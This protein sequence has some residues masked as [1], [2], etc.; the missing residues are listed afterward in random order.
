MLHAIYVTLIIVLNP[1]RVLALGITLRR[2]SCA[3]RALLGCGA[4]LLTRGALDVR[5][6][7]PMQ[8]KP[9]AIP[10]VSALMSAVS[11]CRRP[12]GGRNR[13]HQVPVDLVLLAS[14]LL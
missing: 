1:T 2:P 11:E 7:R 4:A 5:K 10:R 6:R 14:P 9:H 12:A 8:R 3:S 13:S